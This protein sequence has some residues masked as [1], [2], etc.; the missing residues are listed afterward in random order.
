MISSMKVLKSLY[1]GL[2]SLAMAGGLAS[3]END[4]DAPRFDVPEATKKA[5]TTILDLKTEFW[6][7]ATN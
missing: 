3:C 7:D 6:D 5:N 2:M 4:I 1:I